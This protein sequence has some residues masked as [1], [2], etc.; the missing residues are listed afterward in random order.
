MVQLFAGT[1][2]GWNDDDSMA[3]D[4]ELALE[5][6]MEEGLPSAPQKAV[7]DRRKLFIAITPVGK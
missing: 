2:D 6:L 4:M 7:D 5:E 3:K 1:L